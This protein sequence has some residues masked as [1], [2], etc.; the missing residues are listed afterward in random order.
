MRMLNMALVMTVAAIFV[1]G[2]GK[3]Q[4]GTGSAD[5]GSASTAGGPNGSPDLYQK[6]ANAIYA[7]DMETVKKLADSEESLNARGLGGESPLIGAVMMNK[8]QIAALLIEK[9]ADVNVKGKTCGTALS[10]C[11]MGIKDPEKAAE[12]AAL[13]IE[14]GADVN[15]PVLSNQ[16]P[17]HLAAMQRHMPIARVL[18]KNDADPNGKD[19][20]GRTP[21]H[22]CAPRGWVDMTTL[23][24]ENGA[25]AT[26]K[27]TDGKTALDYAK[28]N[29]YKETVKV[30][31]KHG[32]E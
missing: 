27:D 25:D 3:E 15:M 20:G 28:D 1:A 10:N 24:L 2:C 4:P 23:L 5:G 13:L 18:L 7:D 9:G 6:F 30:L 12:I 21:L 16:T 11:V 32:N 19:D 22:Y 8:P 17:L 14:N 26:V 31:E 29:D